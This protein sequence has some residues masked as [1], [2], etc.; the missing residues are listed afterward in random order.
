MTKISISIFE[1]VFS[2]NLSRNL[3]NLETVPEKLAVNC[4]TKLRGQKR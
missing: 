1:S 3:R 4:E 2:I